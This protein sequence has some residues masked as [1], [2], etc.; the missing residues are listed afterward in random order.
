VVRGAAAVA[1]DSATRRARAADSARRR[2]FA[3]DSARRVPPARPVACSVPGR[4][5]M[6]VGRVVDDSTGRAVAGVGVSVVPECVVSTNAQ[7]AYALG[8]LAPGQYRVTVHSNAY[9]QWTRPPLTLRRDTVAVHDI[10]VAPMHCTDAEAV[11]RLSGIVVDDSTGHPVERVTVMVRGTPCGALTQ[12]DGRFSILG[13]PA[14][15]HRILLRRIGYSVIEIPRE[16]P[17]GRIA[18]IEARMVRAVSRLRP[19]DNPIIR[20]PRGRA[21]PDS[22]PSASAEPGDT[23][24]RA[25]AP[26]RCA[27]PVGTALTARV[28]DASTDRPLAG[29]RVTGVMGCSV[30]TNADGEYMIGPVGVGHFQVTVD[31]PVYRAISEPVVSTRPV[32]SAGGAQVSVPDIRVQP[33][34]SARSP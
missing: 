9:Y 4:G 18:K 31:D 21:T 22:S 13:V 2:T 23:G 16:I 8:P 14:G 1:M 6:L 11:G 3:A 28:I 26:Q 12:A 7:G 32:T 33:A 5:A 34:D 27:V 24:T 25:V 29:V 10:R 19:L 20:V 15:S 17:A 30:Q